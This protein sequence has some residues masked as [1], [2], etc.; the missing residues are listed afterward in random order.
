MM[1]NPYTK[2]YINRF[3]VARD[4]WLHEYL[5]SPIECC[6]NWPESLLLGTRLFTLIS[7]GLI[8]YSCSHFSGPHEPISTKFRL[9]RFFIML[10]LYMVFKMLQCKKKLLWRHHFGTL[11]N[12][13]EGEKFHHFLFSWHTWRSHLLRFHKD[14]DVANALFCLVTTLTV[15]CVGGPCTTLC[16]VDE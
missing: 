5:I 12:I 7:I 6:V 4:I 14:V 10:Y 2:L 13:G 9:W 8:R 3:M 1:I 15:L 16:S 11:Y